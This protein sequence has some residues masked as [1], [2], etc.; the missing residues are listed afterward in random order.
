MLCVSNGN[1]GLNI[2]RVIWILL[3]L[4]MAKIVVN[5]V[6]AGGN[7]IRPKPV[8][9][10]PEPPKTCKDIIKGLLSAGCG[11]GFL[12]D[13]DGD[14]MTPDDSMPGGNYKHCVTGECTMQQ[15]QS[16]T[17]M[18]PCCQHEQPHPHQLSCP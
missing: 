14:A 17:H 11:E 8:T 13:M 4:Q 18:P 16:I 15:G 9:F 7:S 2:A 6:D 12:E 1:F 3:A 10:K 5:V